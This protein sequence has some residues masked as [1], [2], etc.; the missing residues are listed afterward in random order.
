MIPN[1]S[2][3]ERSFA[4]WAMHACKLGIATS[5]STLRPLRHGDACQLLVFCLSGHDEGS[6]TPLSPRKLRVE[7]IVTV[8]H[9][10]LDAMPANSISDC[11]SEEIK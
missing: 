11:A 10:I 2:F 3:N 6:Y 8:V 4:A 7:H 9:S 5:T 1:P